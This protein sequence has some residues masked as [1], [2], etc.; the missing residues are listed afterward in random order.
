MFLT[1]YVCFVLLF[2][3]TFGWK[4]PFEKCVILEC[5]DGFTVGAAGVRVDA[6]S[7]FT[8]G[9]DLELGAD[10]DIVFGKDANCEMN[11]TIGEALTLSQISG[12]SLFVSSSEASTSTSTGAMVVAG[13]LGVG[14]TLSVTTMQVHDLTG[15]VLVASTNESI[16]IETG[17]FVALGGVGIAKSL[18]VGDKIENFLPSG[19]ALVIDSTD[20]TSSTVTGSIVTSGGI[21]VTE[22]MNVGGDITISSA[23]SIDIGTG[24]TVVTNAGITFPFGSSTLGWY[25]VTSVTFSWTGPW[26]SPATRDTTLNLARLGNMITLVSTSVLSG[27]CSAT[28]VNLVS[29]TQLPVDFRPAIQF[30]TAARLQNAGSAV[31]TPGLVISQVDG[32]IQIRN[33]FGTP[34]AW[35]SSGSCGIL[36]FAVSY[37]V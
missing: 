28:N 35:S 6:I 25:E 18:S 7:T 11:A 32:T 20:E 5:K 2:P 14:G 17:A 26:S 22:T 1:S 19:T 29:T 31:S 3:L 12:T 33:R 34:V 37:M 16:G 8:F 27:T 9:S 23:G 10:A 21:G 13:G 4:L 36:Y 15:Q 24:T 30:E